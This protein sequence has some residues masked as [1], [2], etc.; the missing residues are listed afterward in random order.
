[1]QKDAVLEHA[2]EVQYEAICQC[3]ADSLTALSLKVLWASN[4]ADET[5]R[6]LPVMAFGQNSGPSHIIA[7]APGM[8]HPQ[9]SEQVMLMIAAV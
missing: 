3:Q 8:T 4:I 6:L 7:A 2:S 9:K 5:P 1:M